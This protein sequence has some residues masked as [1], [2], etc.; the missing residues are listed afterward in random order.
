MRVN[1]LLLQQEVAPGR[2]QS[3]RPHDRETDQQRT[4]SDQ[5]QRVLSPQDSLSLDD[6]PLLSFAPAAANGLATPVMARLLGRRADER[7]AARSAAAAPDTP[8]IPTFG[9]AMSGSTAAAASTAGQQPAPQQDGSAASDTDTA[10]A[11]YLQVPRAS[12]TLL[13]ARHADILEAATRIVPGTQLQSKAGF[14][15][16]S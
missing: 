1:E 12:M 13:P 10:G 14:H 7:A 5:R 9:A 15:L 8:P 4:D 6:D 3:S 16:R 2:R 11:P